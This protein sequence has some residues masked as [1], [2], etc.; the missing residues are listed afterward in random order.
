M[1]FAEVAGLIGI[2]EHSQDLPEIGRQRVTQP[3]NSKTCIAAE[4][5]YLGNSCEYVCSLAFNFL[6]SN[7]LNWIWDKL[8]LYAVSGKVWM[9]GSSVH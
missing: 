8:K 4:F 7:N 9:T 1:L 2:T 3:N 5:A 6:A